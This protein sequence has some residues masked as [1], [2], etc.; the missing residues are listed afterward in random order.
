MFIWLYRCHNH[1]SIYVLLFYSPAKQTPESHPWRL[2]HLR[3]V[4][5]L[6][7]LRRKDIWWLSGLP[8][9]EKLNVVVG[10]I[11]VLSQDFRGLGS[12]QK[13]MIVEGVKL[14]GNKNCICCTPRRDKELKLTL[15]YLMGQGKCKGS[16]SKA[17]QQCQ[18][19]VVI[20]SKTISF[21]S[22]RGMAGN[23]SKNNHR[24]NRHWRSSCLGLKSNGLLGEEESQGRDTSPAYERLILFQFHLEK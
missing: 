1:D 22:H 3:K 18:R 23:G 20:Q 19:A 8:R 17:L 21:Q 14:L 2:S 10:H 9:V 6:W 4:H 11:P 7:R 5:V 24:W 13:K 15:K 16:K 12:F